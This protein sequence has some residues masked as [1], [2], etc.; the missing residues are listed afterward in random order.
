MLG[1][2]FCAPAACAGV[3]AGVVGC[4]DKRC[5]KVSGVLGVT[6]LNVFMCWARQV[7]VVLSLLLSSSEPGLLAMVF[8]GHLVLTLQFNPIDPHPFIPL[9]PIKKVIYGMHLHLRPRPQASTANVALK[10]VM[11]Q[12]DG[13]TV[14][15]IV[16]LRNT[17][18]IVGELGW[19][20]GCARMSTAYQPSRA[21]KTGPCWL[22]CVFGQ[23]K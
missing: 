12:G 7:Y 18:H 9:I 23:S 14:F 4:V 22:Q 5:C 11:Q 8:A 2:K 1:P 17:S 15:P 16:G 6:R 19:S 3:V 21:W 20:D 10:W 13:N